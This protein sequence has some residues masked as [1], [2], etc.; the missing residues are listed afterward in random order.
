MPRE[1]P[2]KIAEYEKAELT[3]NKSPHEVP[4]K[5]GTKLPRVAAELPGNA[6]R[7]LQTQDHTGQRGQCLWSSGK[8]AVQE[9][10]LWTEFYSPYSQPPKI[11]M[12]KS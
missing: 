7:S 6:A 8:P 5:L 10:V 4:M 2:M 11:Y 1:R 12:L 3:D 9:A